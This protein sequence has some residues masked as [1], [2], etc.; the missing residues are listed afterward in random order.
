MTT[1][2][3]FEQV[4]PGDIIGYFHTMEGITGR[5]WKNRRVTHV[6]GDHFVLKSGTKVYPE[7]VVGDI[8]LLDQP[9]PWAVEDREGD[10][11]DIGWSANTVTLT[12]PGYGAMPFDIEDIEQLIEAL[13]DAKTEAE[14]AGLGFE[15]A[16]AL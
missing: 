5:Y 4:Q 1:I 3:S 9:F 16:K 7:N 8:Q 14:I 2:I 12:I 6:Y 13:A 15:T 10:S 11:I